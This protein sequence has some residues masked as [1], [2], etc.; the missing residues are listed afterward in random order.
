MQ[1][2]LDGEERRIIDV[3]RGNSARMNALI[4]D[5]VRYSRLNRQPLHATDVDMSML[6]AEA[7]R[8]V[9]PGAAPVLELEPL[10]A[11]R[12]DR[13][14]L[15]QVWVELLGNALKFSTAAQPPRIAVSAERSG[16][17]LIYRVRDNGVGFDMSYAKK[18]F[19]VFQRL[20][21]ARDF[22]GNG[23]G[24]AN[25]ARIVSRHGGRVG[26]QGAVGEGATFWFAL[27]AP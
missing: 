21:G 24:L 25:V 19:S 15:K 14:L 18:L 5:L 12:G 20:H 26:A 6:V 2:R 23:I 11:A 17:E 3:V 13:A 16:D 27:P 22:P 9:Q 1:D 7:V 4:E 10:P 8:T